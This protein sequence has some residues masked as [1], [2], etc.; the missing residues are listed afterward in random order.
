MDVPSEE[1]MCHAEAA[2]AANASKTSHGS[3]KGKLKRTIKASSS[4]GRDD[5]EAIFAAA[6]P[7]FSC[8]AVSKSEFEFEYLLLL[9]LE[10]EC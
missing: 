10:F 9:L 3:N 2:A 1:K 5:A 8:E 4:S 7:G 6:C